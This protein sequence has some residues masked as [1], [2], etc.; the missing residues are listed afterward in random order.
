MARGKAHN[1]GEG[2]REP[3]GRLSRKSKEI[4][5]KNV[6]DLETALALEA[7][8][9]QREKLLK[10]EEFKKRI[11]QGLLVDG[12][13]PM[14]ILRDEKIGTTHGRLFY[15]G[16]D[17]DGIS[18]DQWDAANWFLDIRNKYHCAINSAEGI[19]D[20]PEG[21]TPSD[22]PEAYAKYCDTIRARWADVERAI[23]DAVFECRDK[24]I[25]GA[26]DLI[27]VQQKMD[28]SMV[29][30]LRIALNAIHKVR[31]GEKKKAA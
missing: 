12:K 22:D 14:S 31:I 17:G 3:N 2:D 19:L 25:V 11:P 5:R 10:E 28:Y 23:V 26:L 4:R 6:R 21:Y 29:G 13:I 15:V 24:N 27:I 7:G 20:T 18:R 1:R 30:E 9:W 16:P 8:L